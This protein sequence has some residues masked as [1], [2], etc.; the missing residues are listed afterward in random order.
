MLEF[1][2]TS[3]P[4]MEVF[5]VKKDRGKGKRKMPLFDTFAAGLVK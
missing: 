1:E 4:G 5:Y 3:M 2:M